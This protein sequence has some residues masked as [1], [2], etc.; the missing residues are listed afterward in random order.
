MIPL[1]TDAFGAV[2]WSG[3]TFLAGIA[4]KGAIAEVDRSRPY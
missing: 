3:V 1:L 4:S 2:A